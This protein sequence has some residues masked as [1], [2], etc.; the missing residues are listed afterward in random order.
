MLLKCIIF[1]SKNSLS[2]LQR[3]INPGAFAERPSH[4]RTGASV[5]ATVSVWVFFLF[6]VYFACAVKFC[7]INLLPH[8]DARRLLDSCAAYDT[9]RTRNACRSNKRLSHPAFYIRD[10]T[11]KRLVLGIELVLA[12]EFIEF[13]YQYF[14]ESISLPFLLTSRKASRSPSS[15]LPGKHLAPLPPHFQESISLP[16]LLTSRIPHLNRKA[17]SRVPQ[18]PLRPLLCII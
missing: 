6:F 7:H 15:S 14:Q 4:A 5:R 12:P 17:K 2:N 18:K 13:F 8:N 16:F 1:S 11:F 9:L 10:S 3:K